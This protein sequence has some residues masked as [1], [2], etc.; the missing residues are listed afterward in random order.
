MEK[1]D[2]QTA[3]VNKKLETEVLILLQGDKSKSFLIL[4]SGLVEILYNPALKPG[5]SPG[6]ILE[7][8]LRIGLIKGN[9]LID[10]MGL[11]NSEESLSFSIRTISNCII[12]S[13]PTEADEFISLM[14]E[15]LPLN[16]KVLRDLISRIESSVYIFKNYKYLWHKYASIADTLALGCKIPESAYLPETVSREGSSLEEYATFLNLR[17]KENMVYKKCEPWDYNLFLGR[18]Q[19]QLDLYKDH[20]D[21]RVEDIIDNRQYLFIKRLVQKEDKVLAALFR[22][23]EPSNRYLF[24]ILGETIAKMLD[25]NKN[26]ACEIDGLMNILYSE[27]GWIKRI[28]TENDTEDLAVRNFIHFLTKFSWRCRK[29]THLLLGKDILK[30]YTVFSSLKKFKEYTAPQ[31]IVEQ[32]EGTDQKKDSKRLLKYKGLFQKILD[33]SGMSEEFK[34]NLTQLMDNLIK[35]ENKF[36]SSPDMEKLRSDLSE[37]YWELYEH[38]FLKIIDSDLK[39]FIPGIMLHFGLIDERLLNARELEL[40]DEFY[41]GN[42]YSD[43]TIPVMTLPYFLEKIYKSTINPSM[44]EMGDNFQTVLKNQEKMTR[45]EKEKSYL[46]E[47]T[48]EDRVR[49]EIRK[50]AGDLSRVLFGNKK[51]SLCGRRWM[52]TRRTALADCSFLSI[53]R[54]N[55][56]I[57][58]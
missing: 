17:I 25:C 34:D 51:K 32:A 22:K 43:E 7:G 8:S 47:N 30:E 21:L 18:L 2:L 49:F 27:K 40:I 9:A 50:I 39:G 20:D 35:S 11:L 4:H 24:N 10:V 12:T 31:E 1:L 58:C 5:S 41:A 28:I 56:R 26:L 13:R 46:F 45:K 38:C 44:T 48:P 33:F 29:D 57:L 3:F 15:D 14:Q 53:L 52:E 16:L 6:E 19:D 36:A 54:G 42:L 55:W 23:D 37:K